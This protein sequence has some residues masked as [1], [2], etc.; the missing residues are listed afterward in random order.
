ML[1]DVRV[2]RKILSSEYQ[3]NDCAMVRQKWNA[4][5]KPRI[6]P[7]EW[8][9]EGADFLLDGGACDPLLSM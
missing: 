2:A 7:I 8:H 3:P 9:P 4:V 6:I 1:P 5:K